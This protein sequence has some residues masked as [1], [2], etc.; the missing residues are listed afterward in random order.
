MEFSEKCPNPY[1]RCHGTKHKVIYF[2]DGSDNIDGLAH[3]QL[4]CLTC[5]FNFN[6]WHN[7]S[8]DKLK[9]VFGSQYHLY[10]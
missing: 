3:F 9:E 7:V 2:N 4:E 6:R 10:L 5:G 8:I 1:S